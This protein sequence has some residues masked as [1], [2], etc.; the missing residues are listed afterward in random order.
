MEK[1][2]KEKTKPAIKK[3][4]S[5]E[6]PKKAAAKA[7]KPVRAKAPAPARQ[8]VK[9]KAKTPEAAVPK[10]AQ[11]VKKKET[12]KAAVAPMHHPA[13][14]PPAAAVVEKK[15]VQA[16]PAA[17]VHAAPKAATHLPPKEIHKKEAP[18]PAAP[19]AKPAAAPTA[20]V[21]P[22]PVP[23]QPAPKPLKD[24]VLELPVTV[25][26]VSVKLQEK[27]SV[28]I[29]T[30][31]GMR[32][33]AGIN[34]PLSEEVVAKILERYGYRP[35]AAPDEEDTMLAD[36]ARPDAAAD[37]KHRSPIVTL[38]G[39]VDHG[40]TSLLDAIRKS[41]VVDSEFGGI[42]QHIG[43]YRVKL[44]KGEITFLDTP[45][46]E[47]FTA[48]RARGA[49]AT[50]IVVIVVAA[51]DGVMPQTQEAIDHAKA[52]GVTIIVAL[53]K[54]DKPQADPDRV[55]KQLSGLGLLSEDW[56]GKTIMAP[57]SAKTGQGIDHLLEMILLESEMLELKANPRRP[58]RGVVLEG[59][60]VKN[61]GPVSTLLIQ[62]G[63]LHLN[64][65]LIVGPLYGKIRAMFNDRG[66]SVTE[67]GPSSPVEILGISGVPEAGE[68][69]FVIGDERLAKELALKRQEKTRLKQME[70]VKRLNLEGL[71]SQIKAGKIK[72][73]NIVLKADAQGS[74]EAIKEALKKIPSD[75]VKLVTIHEGIGNIN[76]S[77]AILAVA[78]DALVL[79]FNV[80][81]DDL[82]KSIIDKE[83][84][85]VR[86]YNIIYELVN[87]IRAALEGM[88]AP[89]LKKIFLGRAEVRK[90]F[91]LSSGNFAGCYVSKGKI[92]RNA[93]VTL[94]RNGSPV[95]DGELSSLK[96]FKDD[97]REV[98]E[99]FECG[100]ALKGFNDVMEGDTIE[101]YT[102][103]KIARTF[104]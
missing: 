55:K 27:P 30:L 50:D 96:R 45:G 20:A 41:K 56:G 77:D 86:I 19:A 12:V 52:A 92:M 48:M 35:V 82:A 33:M 5:P 84:L 72:E 66:Q 43:A 23:A 83:G 13:P 62:N 1:A 97:V 21:A 29:K 79:G 34:Q 37:L 8:A 101:A 99:G 42:T 15:P 63:T 18:K 60:M 22:Q 11:A 61:K 80:V 38:M 3:V 95:F 75:E 65:S 9:A 87:E 7:L 73:L 14:A 64:E 93:Q 89:K 74:I 32:V 59:K 100:M 57:V 4:E 81:T 78:S 102:I 40:K 49:K 17:P 68:Q 26:D 36:H 10:P 46:H 94:V 39:H 70:P 24:L 51:D 58:A 47:A 44:P 54:I 85:D 69:F 88:L 6:K 67:A 25:K 16:K 28:L 76:A 103:Q 31:M 98:E 2:K 90:I 53:N 91:K 71:Y 104:E